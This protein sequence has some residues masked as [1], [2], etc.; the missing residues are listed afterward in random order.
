[1]FPAELTERKQWVCVGSDKLPMQAD[2]PEPAS[3]TN[4]L[5]WNTYELA[6]KSVDVGN[7]KY[8]GYVFTKEDGIVGI[9]IDI[10]FEDNGL[11]PNEISLDIIGAIGSYTELSKSGRGFHIFV[12]GKLPFA[13]R[14]NRQGL[15]IY[16]SGRYFVMTGKTVVYNKIIENQAGV[17]YV[18]NKYFKDFL[19]ESRAGS[20]S[21]KRGIVNYAAD[22]LEQPSE[23]RICLQPYYP[24]IQKGSRNTSLLSL[25]GQLWA[26]GYSKEYVYHDLELANDEACSPPLTY[27]ELQSITN[28]VV[29]YRRD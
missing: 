4:P 14:N 7:Y 18:V 29:K 24:A 15:E 28:S 20:G 11:L 8:V 12:K 13:G 23:H 19:N 27:R 3:S 5:T 10:G 21:K 22:W 1:M 2:R 26:S 6:Q 9:D 17:D 25:G 16:E